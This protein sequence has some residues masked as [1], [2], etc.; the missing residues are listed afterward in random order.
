M[1]ALLSKNND[2]ILELSRAILKEAE[3]LNLTIQQRR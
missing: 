2:E 3:R 1:A